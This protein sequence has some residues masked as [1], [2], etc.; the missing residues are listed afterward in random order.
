MPP[1]PPPRKRGSSRG[2]ME[3][4]ALEPKR[5]STE[6]VRKVSGDSIAGNVPPV[7]EEMEA[8][9]A[10]ATDE[11]V[12][13]MLADLDALQREVEAARAAAAGGGA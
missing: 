3:G 9:D 6:S 2:S 7:A 1:P 11:A 13:A 12:Q 8:V 4:S 5:T 10:T